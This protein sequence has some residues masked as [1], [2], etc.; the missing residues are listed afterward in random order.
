MAHTAVIGMQWGDE[1]KGKIV[2]LLCP[3]FDA[4]VRFQG[5]NNAGH[6]VRFGEHHFALH[7]I[8]SGVLRPGM[9]CVL[10]NGMV[11]SPQA[12]FDELD[13]L[14]TAGIESAGRLFVSRRAHL[15]LPLHIELDRAREA[16]L[17]SGKIGTT[18]RGIGPAYE[19]KASR[20]G[21]RAEGATTEEM[22]AAS[23]AEGFGP[24]VIRRILLGTYALSAGYYDAFY[25]QAQ[26]VRTLIRQQ[27]A[28][29][30]ERVDVLVAPTS[31]TTAFPLGDR[32][33][34]PIAMYYADV[35]TIP[36]NLTGDPG[37]SVPIGLDSK[38]LPIGFQVMAPALEEERL[39]QV[40]KEV[41][42]IVQFAPRPALAT[43]E[44]V[45]P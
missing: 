35:C 8:P 33:D 12:L 9:F 23:R 26:R 30:Y 38:G 19:A 40:A 17:G 1:G 28:A 31:P 3:A 21:L 24:E 25:G 27:F 29:A 43:S 6:T 20:F 32:T 14:E 44:V 45:T 18:A 36:I 22:M 16:A 11:I 10:G 34:D 41:E 13:R 42:N 5:G 2:D 15:I 37:I 4:V 7:L 39:F